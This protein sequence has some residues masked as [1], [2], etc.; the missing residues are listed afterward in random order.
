MLCMKKEPIQ[1][2]SGVRDMSREDQWLGNRDE[3]CVWGW[4]GVL[5]KPHMQGLIG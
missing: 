4:N 3:E 2:C 5:M 1:K